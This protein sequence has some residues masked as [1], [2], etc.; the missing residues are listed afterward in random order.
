M[1]KLR[2]FSSLPKQ[3]DRVILRVDFNVP[4]AGNQILDKT[5]IM[6]T[7][8]TINVLKKLASKL[9]ILTH[10]GRPIGAQHDLS[11]RRILGA[12]KEC[13]NCDVGFL[14]IHADNYLKALDNIPQKVVLCEN[15]RFDHREQ[16]DDITYAKRLARMGEVYVYD[17][18]GCANKYHAS[19]HTLPKLMPAYAGSLMEKEFTTLRKFMSQ[20][21]VSK[22]CVIIGGKKL[23][24]KFNAI[25]KM[26][27]TAD[28][29]VLAGGIANTF[30]VAKGYSLGGSFYDEERV[31]KAAELLLK[32][33]DKI[34]LPV[35]CIGSHDYNKSKK[36]SKMLDEEF[37]GDIGTNTIKIIINILRRSDKVIVNGPLGIYEEPNFLNGT[38]EIM[39]EISR[40]TKQQKLES[41]AGGG[42]I[43]TAI[44]KIEEEIVMTY[45]ST[46]GGAFL[47][48]L[49]GQKF[50]ITV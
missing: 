8:P 18:F 43:I 50:P 27:E 13:M 32:Y 36:I 17:A 15:L 20:D 26:L 4:I 6:T 7:L 11:T 46:G 5:R 41:L 14:D 12:L 48:M 44:N 21:D 1:T 2:P 19:V 45:K 37:I 38:K 33:D 42:D 31:N 10:F 22:T 3:L 28:T 30:L 23:S 25:S 35:D 47:D 9:I 24:T 16:E 34:I 40:L 39:K 29:M 49:A